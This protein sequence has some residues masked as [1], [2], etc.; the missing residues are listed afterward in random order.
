MERAIFVVLSVLNTAYTHAVAECTT[1]PNCISSAPDSNAFL[2]YDD[3]ALLR[4]AN[5]L[6]SS[7]WSLDLYQTSTGGMLQ[8]VGTCDCPFADTNC[9]E[10]DEPAECED[11]KAKARAQNIDVMKEIRTGIAWMLDA[12]EFGPQEEKDLDAQRLERE[13]KEVGWNSPS[14]AEEAE[15]AGFSQEQLDKAERDLRKVQAQFDAD[16]AAQARQAKRMQKTGQPQASSAPLR[17]VEAPGLFEGCEVP[18][19]LC[20]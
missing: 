13:E 6:N 10:C 2:A 7:V 1:A 3:F 8:P 14:S 17:G 15:R 4:I 19:R 20:R 16:A 5:H 9:D 11:R 12:K 18:S